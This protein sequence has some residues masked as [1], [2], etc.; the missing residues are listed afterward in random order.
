MGEGRR[1]SSQRRLRVASEVIERVRHVRNHEIELVL[2]DES[3]MEGLELVASSDIH[4]DVQAKGRIALI[5][6]L[7]I[8][9]DKQRTALQPLL[10][11]IKHLKDSI[12]HT[13]LPSLS[14]DH[15]FLFLKCSSTLFIVDLAK[16]LE[17]MVSAI[18]PISLPE[19]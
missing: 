1:T 10:T 14:I 12:D 3:V 6:L 11:P 2:F 13:N 15:G 9:E 4:S 19:L 16:S 18:L 5:H 8:M 7:I 17:D